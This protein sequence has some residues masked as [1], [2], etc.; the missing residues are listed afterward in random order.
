MI[1]GDEE[2]G[3]RRVQASSGDEHEAVQTPSTSLLHLK[4]LA[5]RTLFFND[6]P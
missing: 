6:V 3:K 5:A 4:R 1:R 2:L